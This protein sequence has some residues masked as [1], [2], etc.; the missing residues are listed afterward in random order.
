MHKKLT[1]FIYW[2]RKL[3]KTNTKEK[4]TCCQ[5]GVAAR[6]NCSGYWELASAGAEWTCERGT[7]FVDING[8]RDPVVHQKA[9]YSIRLWCDP[10]NLIRI[11]ANEIHVR[12]NEP[13]DRAHVHIMNQLNKCNRAKEL[14][15]LFCCL[16]D[17]A[18]ANTI[19]THAIESA[20]QFKPNRTELKR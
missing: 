10:H 7:Y 11:V 6:K 8:E 4:E 19:W 16:Q 5:S 20:M 13:A 17:S 15:S 12:T 9:P 3:W 2:K 18:H 14:N 1:E